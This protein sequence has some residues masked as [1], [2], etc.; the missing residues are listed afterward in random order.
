MPEAERA[1][2]PFFLGPR[3]A[4]A[5]HTDEVRD[6]IRAAASALGLDPGAV[7]EAASQS[8]PRFAN[9]TDGLE[10]EGAG[11]RPDELA[12]AP[13]EGPRKPGVAA[14]HPGKDEGGNCDDA[15]AWNTEKEIGGRRKIGVG[16]TTG[17]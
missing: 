13:V 16:V 1:S 14:I 3:G 2:T 4:N 6:A 8:L 15:N 11:L 5:V 12:Q 7:E 10:E 17:R 9:V